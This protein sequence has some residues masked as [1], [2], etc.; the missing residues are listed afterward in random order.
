MPRGCEHPESHPG[1]IQ[2]ITISN[3]PDAGVREGNRGIHGDTRRQLRERSSVISMPVRQEHCGDGATLHDRR[4][5]TRVCWPWINHDHP[6][7]PMSNPGVRSFQSESSR[8]RGEE[9]NW[10]RPSSRSETTEAAL[11]LLDW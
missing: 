3:R 9:T 5:M 4:E 7:Q 8:V 11:P 2:Q 6:R 1:E 10:T